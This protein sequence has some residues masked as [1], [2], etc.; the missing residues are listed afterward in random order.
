MIEINKIIE[1]AKHYGF[2]EAAY[3]NVSSINLYDEVRNMCEENKCRQYNTNWSCPPG[4]GDLEE[5]RQKL[6][7]Y[8]MGVIVQTVG[9]IEDSLDYESMMDIEKKHKKHF[10]YFYKIIKETYKDALAFGSGCCTVCSKCTYPKDKC[11][12]PKQCVSS[13]E[14]YGMLVS[15]I[16]KLNNI[17]YYYG[18]NKIA[19][20]SCFVI[21]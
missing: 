5:G 19:Y 20:T 4:C 11:R 1:Q 17:K 16:C 7:N 18:L 10:Y 13:M 14:A 9:E 6:A 3:L 15:E 12:F 21:K 2:D 8:S